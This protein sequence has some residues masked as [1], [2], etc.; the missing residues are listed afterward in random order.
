MNKYFH[1]LIIIFV[2]IKVSFPVVVFGLVDW[3]DGR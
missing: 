3:E 2:G 1:P